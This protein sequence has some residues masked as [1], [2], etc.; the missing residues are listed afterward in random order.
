MSPKES[1]VAA[2]EHHDPGRGEGG[3]AD[4]LRHGG[5]PGGDEEGG[6]Q[7]GQHGPAPD[8]GHLQVRGVAGFSKII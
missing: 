6:V 3:E 1:P 4:Q 2:G 7:P 5:H 8:P